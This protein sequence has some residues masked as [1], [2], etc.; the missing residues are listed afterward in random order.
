MRRPPRP[1]E[2]P[3]LTTGSSPGSRV[4][5]GFTRGRGAGL[6][7]THDG[8]AD[9]A[10]WLAYTTLVVAQVVRAYAN[11]SLS[12]QSVPAAERLPARA[13]ASSFVVVQ[14]VIPY[15]P[16][17]GRGVPRHAAGYDRLGIRPGYRSSAGRG[18]RSHP[19]DDRSGV[20][21]LTAA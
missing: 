19:G 12:R 8:S 14:V 18:R 16:A 4:A 3:L 6:M 17:A 5:G 20:G 15:R 9:H 21:R 11:R 10:R 2:R 7:L 1:R 13:R